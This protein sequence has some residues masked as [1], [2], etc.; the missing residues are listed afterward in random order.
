[1][2]RHRG[3]NQTLQGRQ[4]SRS[5]STNYE[6]SFNPIVFIYEC[7]NDFG[8]FVF[9]VARQG[10]EFRDPILFLSH[11]YCL[12]NPN[13]GAIPRPTAGTIQKNKTL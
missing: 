2:L 7:E 13:G 11:F 6:N 5:I 9:K 1:V 3:N 10:E 8:C 12:I 4:A